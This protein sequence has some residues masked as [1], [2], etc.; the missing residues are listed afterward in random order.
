MSAK[1]RLHEEWQLGL[2]TWNPKGIFSQHANIPEVAIGHLHVLAT[3]IVCGAH[4]FHCA[5]QGAES[6]GKG[7]GLFVER[8]DV[9]CH[10][11]SFREV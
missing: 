10:D 1:A 8:Q 5:Q 3:R 6:S 2:K 9:D 11:R 7:R 4:A